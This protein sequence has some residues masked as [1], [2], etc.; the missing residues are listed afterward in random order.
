MNSRDPYLKLRRP[1]MPPEEELC[2]CEGKNPIMLVGNREYNPIGCLKCSGEVEPGA[3]GFDEKL[4]EKVA[5]WGRLYRSI[6]Y[7]WLESREYESWA[8][9]E[10]SNPNSPPNKRGFQLQQE[11]NRYRT[12]YYWWFQDIGEE[13]FKP[14]EKCPVCSEQL[15]LFRE[16]LL[17]ETC[18]IVMQGSQ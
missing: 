10:L 5:F 9:R 14:L 3:L 6:D 2:C 4:A 13:Q 8:A 7:L 18:Q 12:C 1:P 17:C 16:N 15:V 11:L